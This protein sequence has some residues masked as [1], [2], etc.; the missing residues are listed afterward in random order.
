MASVGGVEL[1]GRMGRVG[2]KSPWCV[3]SD[4]AGVILGRNKIA[5]A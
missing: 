2:A 5:R 3:S 4:D 1:L